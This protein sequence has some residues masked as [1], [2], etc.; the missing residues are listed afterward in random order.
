MNHASGSRQ[1]LPASTGAAVLLSAVLLACAP[2]APTS[3]SQP[4]PNREGAAIRVVLGTPRDIQ[5][6]T[7]PGKTLT[8]R[9]VRELV[10]R[11]V[12]AGNDTLQ[13][14]LSGAR[15]SGERVTSVRGTVRLPSSEDMQVTVL[16]RSPDM[17]N[18]IGATA[19]P[20]VLVFGALLFIWAMSGAST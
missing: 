12:F 10:G 15:S 18:A 4:A 17:V 13:I 20:G 3:S 8:L 2:P 11:A 16:S 1:L 7:A 6:V 9:N 5:V 19:I 14:A